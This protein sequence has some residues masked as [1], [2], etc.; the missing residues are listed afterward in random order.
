M[1]YIILLVFLFSS[2]YI[3]NKNC[4][5]KYCN[6]IN[7]H[8]EWV[9]GI[10]VNGK[11]KKGCELCSSLH[12]FGAVPIDP[13]GN[14]VKLT[15]AIDINKVDNNKESCSFGKENCKYCKRK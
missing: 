7:E 1:K 15:K 10:V 12:G 6:I 13:Y 8:P 14:I 4:K 2:C 9:G 11:I 5:Y 3:N